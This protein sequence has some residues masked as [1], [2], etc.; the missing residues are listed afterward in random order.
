MVPICIPA[1]GTVPS[2]VV[3]SRWWETDVSPRG[4]QGPKRRYAPR[5]AVDSETPY[6]GA[7]STCAHSSPASTP[8]WH[9]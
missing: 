7:D 8:R 1:A 4:G 5:A 6:T 2:S 3:A 9:S